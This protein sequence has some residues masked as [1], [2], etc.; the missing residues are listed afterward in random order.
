MQQKT[1]RAIEKIEHKMES[2]SPDTLRYEALNTAKNFK[3]SWIGLGQVLN[4]VWRDKSYKGWGYTEFESYVTKEIGIRK[5]TAL[6]LLRSYAFLENKEP[7]YLKKDYT[8]DTNAREVPTYEAVDVLRRASTNKNLDKEDYTKIKKY[9]LDDGKD[10]K[11]VKK[12][13][14]EIIKS[15]EE[16][17]S[18]EAWQKKRTSI[19]KRFL[20]LL[21]SIKTELKALKILPKDILNQTEVLINKI[22]NDL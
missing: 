13:L 7:H 8:Q 18:E 14:S 10:V 5:E 17:D 9:V 15:R 3:T 2:I 19:V 6:K 4:T 16:T 20:N 21:K 1:N 22:E 11:G 12:D